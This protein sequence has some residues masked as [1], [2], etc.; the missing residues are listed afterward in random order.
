LCCIGIFVGLYLVAATSQFYYLPVSIASGA[1]G[2]FLIFRNFVS[3]RNFLPNKTKA[4]KNSFCC[5]LNSKK[6]NIDK[7]G[8]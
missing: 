5:N 2:D 6:E 3:F 7:F 4:D 8:K 1:V